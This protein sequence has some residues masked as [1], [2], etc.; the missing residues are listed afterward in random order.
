MVDG[1]GFLAAML[2]MQKAIGTLSIRP[3]WLI[4]S[5]TFG[6]HAAVILCFAAFTK[7][8]ASFQAVRAMVAL[9]PFPP[10]C[11]LHDGQASVSTLCCASLGLRRDRSRASFPDRRLHL[12]GRFALACGQSSGAEDPPSPPSPTSDSSSRAPA[13]QPGGHHRR[14]SASSSSTRVSKGLLFLCVG[15]VEQH[16]LA[17]TSNPC[18]ACTESCPAWQSSRC[19]GI[20]AMMLPPFSAARQV[21]RHRS[22]HLGP[23]LHARA[24]GAHRLRQR[25]SAVLFW[26]PLG[27]A[28]SLGGDPLGDK[29]PV[30]GTS[31][32]P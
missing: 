25:H 14:H 24:R 13:W 6:R 10:C 17:L 23:G 2:F 20:A 3:C 27:P 12:C 28:C 8:A 9:R 18:A 29:R 15:T 5:H 26:A 4:V 22:R 19:S 30:P 32:A 1:I 21:D 16:R 11:L 31:T 7:S